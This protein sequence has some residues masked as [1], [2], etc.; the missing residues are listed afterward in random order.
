M[1]H[2]EL[3]CGLPSTHSS[4]SMK[5]NH[6]ASALPHYHKDIETSSMRSPYDGHRAATRT[7]G[8]SL[9]KHQRR[10]RVPV[11]GIAPI[12]GPNAPREFMIRIPHP[13]LL[14]RVSPDAAVAVVGARAGGRSGE[15]DGCC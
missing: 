9:R 12:W 1:S 10:E 14:A 4:T 11:P 8:A 6:N 13:R 7:S 5:G 15:R 2:Y 3:R